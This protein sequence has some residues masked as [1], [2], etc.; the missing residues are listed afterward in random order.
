MKKKN[1]L[2]SN[3]YPKCISCKTIFFKHKA[4]GLCTKCYPVIYQI[5]IVDKWN[6]KKPASLR[7]IPGIKK[8]FFDYCKND[9]HYELNETKDYVKSALGKK[10]FYL[11]LLG[12]LEHGKKRDGLQ[13]ETLFNRI[14][15]LANRDRVNIFTNDANIF[16]EKF[17]AIQRN[18]LYQLLLK[19]LIY[20][21][22][23]TDL[24]PPHRSMPTIKYEKIPLNAV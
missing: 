12:E 9:L 11:K 1:F 21:N 7:L 5:N 16:N 23:N 4:Q 19:I 10:L 22:Q 2:W 13:L 17:T 18:L 14:G 8:W 24:T 15:N 20:K 3:K 6:E